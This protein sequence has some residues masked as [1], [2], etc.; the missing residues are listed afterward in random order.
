MTRR[1]LLATLAVALVARS[2]RAD[3]SAGGSGEVPLDG[4]GTA[5]MVR[6]TVNGTTRALFLV[7]TGASYCVLSSSLSRRLG[8]RPGKTTLDLQTANG[9]VTVPLV[10]LRSLD[11]GG[12]R[13]HGV[14]AV[15]HD[16]V[17]APLD[18]II[19]LNFLNQ[20]HYAIDPRRRTLRLR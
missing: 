17:N 1:R 6:A 18:G 12:S 7:D 20:F 15:V 4:D 13:A 11:V 14:Q 8:L 10:E 3:W 5:W 2:A 9:T 16:A 19:G